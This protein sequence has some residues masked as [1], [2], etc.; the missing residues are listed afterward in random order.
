MNF[1]TWIEHEFLYDQWGSSLED[2]KKEKKF[3]LDKLLYN[4][5]GEFESLKNEKGRIVMSMYRAPPVVT[6]ITHA[7]VDYKPVG[8]LWY[9]EGFNWLRWLAS[10][11]PG[12]ASMFIHEIFINISNMCIINDQNKRKEFEE[13]YGQKSNSISN[14]RLDRSI[15]ID[16]KRVCEDFH[17]IECFGDGY[18]RSHDWQHGW[19][20]PSGVIWNQSSLKSSRL[21]YAYDIRSKEFAKASDLGIYAG[22]SSAIKNP[23]PA[24][25][26]NKH[27][28]K[29]VQK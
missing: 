28:D 19:D 6:Q 10:D 16:W 3:A 20:V 14:D 29:Y 11:S 24:I 7:T 21:L 27:R 22:K 2:V 12:W 23:L 17:G 13:K 25:A 5:K 26:M 15:L 9:S 1:K 18:D 4:K 8:G